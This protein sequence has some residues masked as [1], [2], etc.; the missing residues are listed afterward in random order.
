MIINSIKKL[1][2]FEK[3]TKKKINERRKNLEKIN[4]WVMVKKTETKDW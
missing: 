3:D 2:E 4:A 1:K